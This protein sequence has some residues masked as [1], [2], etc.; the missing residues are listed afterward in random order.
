MH[1]TRDY[2]P[3]THGHVCVKRTLTS[4][5][6]IGQHIAPF[7]P[8]SRH[9]WAQTAGRIPD[10][11]GR[12]PNPPG[13]HPKP[14]VASQTSLPCRI[15]PG[16]PRPDW[17]EAGCAPPPLS[18]LGIRAPIGDLGPNQGV[19]A[20]IRVLTPP[21]CLAGASTAQPGQIGDP[22][23]LAG[24]SAPRPG[25]LWPPGVCLTQLSWPGLSSFWGEKG[26]P[27]AGI[28]SQF[29]RICIIYDNVS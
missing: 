2:T 14:S 23:A 9:M 25:Q 13:R 18:V 11:P 5:V 17:G 10:S 26:D 4:R 24:D 29:H 15:L 21:A 20:A 28:F 8:T 22:R 16:I 3:P 7:P 27:A 12:P 6:G 1:Y 19:G